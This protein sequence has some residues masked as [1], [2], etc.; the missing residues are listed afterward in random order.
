V[1]SVRG[2]ETS[3]IGLKDTNGAPIGG[4][5]Q[6]IGN[7]ELLFPFPGLNNDK[8]VRMSAF[9]DTGMVDDRYN[10]SQLRHSVGV[11]VAWIS[12]VGPLKISVAAP[13][14]AKADDRTQKFQFTFGSA[15]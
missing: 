3:S 6:F 13:V 14:N 8:S 11:A 1:T 4:S 12:P 9:F 7:V 2:Y 5:H 10:F 15:F